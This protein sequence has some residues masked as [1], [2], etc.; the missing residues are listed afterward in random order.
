MLVERS[1]SFWEQSWLIPIERLR[2]S[3]GLNEPVLS[4]ELQ[5]TCS[6]HC[7]CHPMQLGSTRKRYVAAFSL[8]WSWEG[9]H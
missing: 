5:A 2:S 9:L 6:M 4:R 7:H 1:E 8:L 3:N